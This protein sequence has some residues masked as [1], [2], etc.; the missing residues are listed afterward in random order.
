[1]LFIENRV[2]SQK[3]LAKD[4]SFARAHLSVR[5]ITHIYLELQLRFKT[6]VSETY[7]SLLVKYGKCLI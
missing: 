2:H 1:M 4:Q 5:A 6:Y 7:S 3:K